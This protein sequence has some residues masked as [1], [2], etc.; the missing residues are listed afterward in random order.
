MGQ[1]AEYLAALENVSVYRFEDQQRL[2]LQDSDGSR[3]VDYKPAR[4]FEL[5]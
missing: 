3:M 4:T 5:T 1:E 2:I